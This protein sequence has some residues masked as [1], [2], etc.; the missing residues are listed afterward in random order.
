M[1]WSPLDRQLAVGN[2]INSEGDVVSYLFNSSF[3]RSACLN[4]Q[5]IDLNSLLPAGS[6][7]VLTEARDVNN[8]DQIA[9]AGA[10]N[11]QIHG[12]LYSCS[13]GAI[14]DLGPDFANWRA[15]LTDA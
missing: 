15:P 2:A 11:G 6:P 7:W 12:F 9:G 10:I 1:C 3:T 8:S 14:V 5:F 4:G 13:T